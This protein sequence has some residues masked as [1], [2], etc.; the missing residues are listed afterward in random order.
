M[1]EF[2]ELANEIAAQFGKFPGRGI[3]L[4]VRQA[5]ELVKFGV[6]KTDLAGQ[7]VHHGRKGRSSRQCLRPAQWPHHCL[8]G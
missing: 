6:F 3:F 2:G 1:V 8:T 7:L 4:G 5:V